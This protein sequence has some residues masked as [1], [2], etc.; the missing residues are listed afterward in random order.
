M[1]L[2]ISIIR[3]CIKKNTNV[4]I[5]NIIFIGIYVLIMGLALSYVETHKTTYTELTNFTI[6]KIGK[7]IIVDL[8]NCPE[9]QYPYYTIINDTT[10]MKAI[11]NSTKFYE[12]KK[13]NLYNAN[14]NNII[15]WSNPPYE[16]YNKI[17]DK[18]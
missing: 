5:K 8:Q 6:V 7:I 9:I 12:I 17:L 15:L 18:K 13:Y 14:T 16:K 11:S 3:I 4:S 10:Q 2:L 1:V